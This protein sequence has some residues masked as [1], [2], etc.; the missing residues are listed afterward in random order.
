MIDVYGECDG[1]EIGKEINKE[2][3]FHVREA[4]KN[5]VKYCFKYLEKKIQRNPYLLGDLENEKNILESLD[6]K[7][8]VKIIDSNF[9]S[10]ILFPNR[11]EIEV[12]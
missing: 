9:S 3:L 6:P 12:A 8:I 11:T 1:Y 2:C 4:F 7:H 5:G 10:A